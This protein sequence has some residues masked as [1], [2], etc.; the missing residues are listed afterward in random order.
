MPPQIS[1][2]ATETQADPARF[3]SPQAY[4]RLRRI[5]AEVDPGDVIR[6]NHPVPPAGVPIPGLG[7]AGRRQ[8]TARSE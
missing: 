4:E 3:W 2:F 6:A 1:V 7:A 8:T 5:K